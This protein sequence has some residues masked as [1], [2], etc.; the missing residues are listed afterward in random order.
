LEHENADSVRLHLSGDPKYLEKLLHFLE[1]HD[2]PRA[3]SVFSP[4]KERAAAVAAF[5]LPGAKLFHH[6]QF[7][8]LKTR[9]PVFLSRG[10][11]EPI[12]EDLRSFYRDL[13]NALS[14]PIFRKGE[15]GLCERSGWPDNSGFHNLVCWSWTQDENRLLVVVNLSEKTVQGL[16]HPGWSDLAG[17]TVDFVDL[18]SGAR[19]ERPGDALASNGLYVELTAWNY[20]VLRIGGERK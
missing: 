15:W 11:E 17:R 6:G 8:G 4:S 12:D 14:D 9:P 16:V 1:N 19:Y 7:E 2:E 20:H 13:L 3:A 5:T 18:L 10:P